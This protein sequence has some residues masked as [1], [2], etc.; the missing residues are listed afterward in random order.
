MHRVVWYVPPSGMY[1]RFGGSK[2]SR[3]STVGC[4]YDSS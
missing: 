4:M 2:V 1:H 3:T